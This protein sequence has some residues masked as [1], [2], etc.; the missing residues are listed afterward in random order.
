MVKLLISKGANTNISNKSGRTPL[1]DA[2]YRSGKYNTTFNLQMK[3]KA[4][5]KKK[6]HV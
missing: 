5:F 1:W 2:V 3:R 6:L 4:F